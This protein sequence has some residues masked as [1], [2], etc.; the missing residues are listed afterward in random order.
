MCKSRYLWYLLLEFPKIALSSKF[1]QRT[2]KVLRN[3]KQLQEHSNAGNGKNVLSI[4]VIQINEV[5][6]ECVMLVS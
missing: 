1:C 5:A 3:T 2:Q 4:I 6:W